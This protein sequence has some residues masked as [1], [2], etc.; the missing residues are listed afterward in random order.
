MKVLWNILLLVLIMASFSNC[1]STQK[2][3]KETPIQFG[4][5]Y[6]QSWV[7]GVQGGGS[8][9]NLYIPIEGKSL[10]SIT[11]DSVY[12]RGKVT[13]LEK[14]SSN[15]L[16]FIGRFLSNSNPK[17]DIILSNEPYAEYGNKL[18]EKN[19]KIPFELKDSECVVSY[20]E[21]KVIKYFKIEHITQ[22]ELLAYPSPP[23]Q[24]KQ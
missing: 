19:I 15:P 21:S 5:V 8:G 18:P 16:V 13:K 23:P 6:C 11:L 1:T 14:K 12:F 24:N 2:L 7:A 17:D 9:L 4:K 22:K 10:P 20:K 3:Q